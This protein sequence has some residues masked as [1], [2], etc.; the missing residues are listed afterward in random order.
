M[1]DAIQ[2]IVSA[3]KVSTD[4]AHHI[5]AV[6]SDTFMRILLGRELGS[7]TD[8]DL[9]VLNAGCAQVANKDGQ[10]V[11]T[12][13]KDLNTVTTSTANSPFGGYAVP[14]S[15]ASQINELMLS[16]SAL[17]NVA[18]VTDGPADDSYWATTNDASD[19][20]GSVGAYDASTENDDPVY[21][22]KPFVTRRATS[23]TMVFSQKWL[24]GA[25]LSD[26]QAHITSLAARRMARAINAHFTTSALTNS[27]SLLNEASAGV[28]I[29][30]NA[31]SFA[32]AGT[33]ENF[34][35]LYFSVDAMYRANGVFMASDGLLN[36]LA[37]KTGNA[38]VGVSALMDNVNPVLT[39][40]GRP[41]VVNTAISDPA[42]SAQVAFFGDF[43]EFVIE[44]AVGTMVMHR[45]VEARYTAQG[46]VGFMLE[47]GVSGN[48][49]QSEAVKAMVVGT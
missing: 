5:A 9:Q 38:P 18:T 45:F 12:G 36:A 31:V 14:V 7:V 43:R 32:V 30:A 6:Q 37:T 40:M 13:F 34:L 22:R 11:G 49:L 10:L 28:T 42:A 4:E 15:V 21:G 25:A 3:Q 24:E 39:V 1:N 19:K 48:L 27:G 46:N 33:S 23:K 2:K 8:S 26:V 29:P 47:R 17:L 16:D 20:T 44:Y 41:V 35:N